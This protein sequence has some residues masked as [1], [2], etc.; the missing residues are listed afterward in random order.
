MVSAVVCKGFEGSPFR[1]LPSELLGAVCSFLV[2]S[3]A[4]AAEDNDADWAC[5]SFREAM[6]LERWSLHPA[7]VKVAALSNKVRLLGQWMGRRVTELVVTVDGGSIPADV[8]QF[9]NNLLEGR[10]L[11]DVLPRL[12][13][14][15][16]R[17]DGLEEE[18]GQPAQEVKQEDEDGEGEDAPMS[19]SLGGLGLVPADLKLLLENF[20][21]PDV[22]P[23]GIRAIEMQQLG[24][25]VEKF[26]FAHLEQ[27]PW[28]ASLRELV[29]VDGA[30]DELDM[31]SLPLLLERLEVHIRHVRLVGALPPS[32]KTFVWDVT[33]KH[34]D[35]EGAAK[36][37]RTLY[38]SFLRIDKLTIVD[39]AMMVWMSPGRPAKVNTVVNLSSLPSTLSTLVLKLDS[40]AIKEA[41]IDEIIDIQ[42][43]LV[44]Q[45]AL[46]EVEIKASSGCQ[47]SQAELQAVAGFFESRLPDH[48]VDT[49]VTQE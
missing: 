5:K 7:V 36:K 30:L 39:Q 23:E 20:P 2:S 10:D 45:S 37:A 12:A 17:T 25:L 22:L 40:W 1:R 13:C 47:L 48:G 46:G 26:N 38:D 11:R 41:S 14:L 19:C 49:T 32:L 21:V 42:G 44:D 24:D 29:I 15:H 8:Q 34:H 16:L 3:D 35:F 33:P 18:D 9:M 4:P 43:I 31:T 27:L 28:P 6:A